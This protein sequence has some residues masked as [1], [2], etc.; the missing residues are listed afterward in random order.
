M[1]LKNMNMRKELHLKERPDGSYVKPQ[2]IFSLTPKE[3]MVSMK[4][5][6]R[7]SIQMAMR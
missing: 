6:N 1:D 4:F 5:L 2:A 7:S 3:R